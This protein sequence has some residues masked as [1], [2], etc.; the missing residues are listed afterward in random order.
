MN[1]LKIE[2]IAFSFVNYGAYSKRMQESVFETS[3]HYSIIDIRTKKNRK[4]L[5]EFNTNVN[6]YLDK[7]IVNET[8]TLR[9]YLSLQFNKEDEKLEEIHSKHNYT[10]PVGRKM[11]IL[12]ALFFIAGEDK[13]LLIELEE[14]NLSGIE[15]KKFEEY[16]SRNAEEFKS[17][18]ADNFIIKHFPDSF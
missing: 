6:P 5:K 7:T 8:I 16:F 2:A 17:E 13:P 3:Y 1:K 4:V 14:L 18:Y 11:N 15:N 10:K 12:P 9:K